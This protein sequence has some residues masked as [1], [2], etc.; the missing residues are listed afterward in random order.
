MAISS[1][2]QDVD[3]YP[4]RSARRRRVRVL[5]QFSA[6]LRAVVGRGPRPNP[7]GQHPAAADTPTAGPRATRPCGATPSRAGP[8]SS[9]NSSNGRGGR[10]EH[11]RRSRIDLRRARPTPAALNV[12]E[13]V[14]PR[15]PLLV[16]HKEGSARSASRDPRRVPRDLRLVDLK[17]SAR[18]ASR[19]PKQGSARSA[20]S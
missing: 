2:L 10:T 13:D 9:H 12:C 3:G 14:D 8:E 17:R 16:I 7:A 18:S 15:D 11:Q 19:D 6:P 20:F 5:D 4:T 1:K